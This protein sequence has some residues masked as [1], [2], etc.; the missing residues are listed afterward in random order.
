MILAAQDI[1]A[2]C[3]GEHPYGRAVA[4]ASILWALQV[5]AANG[6]L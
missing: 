2:R 4:G 6:T 1:I 3:K 5:S